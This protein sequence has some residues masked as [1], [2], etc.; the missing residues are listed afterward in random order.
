MVILLSQQSE[1][2]YEAICCWAPVDST[3]ASK[4]TGGLA[5]AADSAPS[6]PS[7]PA[8]PPATSSTVVFS[9]ASCRVSAET[10]ASSFFYKEAICFPIL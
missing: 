6:D 1:S 10:A 7:T 5:M 9:R 2:A 8:R 3:A 4:G